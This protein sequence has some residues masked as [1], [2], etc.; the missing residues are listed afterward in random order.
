MSEAQTRTPVFT[1]N[2]NPSN[3]IVLEAK[4]KVKKF[5]G[6]IALDRVSFNVRKGEILA[7][8]GE[9]GA[10]KSTLVKILYGVYV[11]D[12]GEIIVDGRKVFITSPIEAIGLGI[13]MVSQVP[14]IIGSLTVAEN[15]ILGLKKYGMISKISRVEKF[16]REESKKTGIEVDPNIEVWKLS[17]TQKQLV[18]LLRSVILGAKVIMLDEAI[19]FLPIQEK[20]RF[21]EFLRRFV[22]EGGS[23]ILITHKIPEALE[24]ADRIT[25]LRRGKVVGTVDAK[26]TTLDEVRRMMFGE[27][28]AEIAYE[29]LPPSTPTEEVVVDVKDL[30]VLGAHGEYAVKG[31]TLEVHAGE[32]FGIAGVA[33]NGQLELIQSVIGLRRPAKGS[34]LLK[35]NSKPIDVS[36]TGIG[37]VRS[38]GVGYIPDEPLKFG[39]SMENNIEENVA[40]L[41][42]ITNGV[43]RWGRIRKLAES[44]IKDFDIKTPS[45]KTKVKLLSGG[46]L[47]KVLVSR[48]LMVSKKLLVAYNPTRALDEVTAI[49]VRRRIKE[50]AL[51][52]KLA[53]LMAS[54]DL[55]EV[56]QVSDKIAVMNSGKIVGVFN[57]QEAKREEIEKLM[58]M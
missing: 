7:L 25:V 42:A 10:G 34:V 9:N 53:V 21:Y 54:E 32:V 20:R 6:V 40:M 17:Y 29:R 15:I 5:P 46:N 36:K 58:V 3:E 55:D 12:E 4:N 2:P 48:E 13:S 41:P 37:K 44:L 33:G 50:K 11:P 30:W 47:M 22:K 31:V 1:Q 51:K 23:A 19:T 35:L 45:S 52:D 57:A 16:I 39:V 49:M 38:A 43:I 8:L 56:L 14:Q 26:K 24:A 27:R 28:S 18:E